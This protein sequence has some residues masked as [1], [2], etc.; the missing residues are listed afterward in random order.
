MPGNDPEPKK[1]AEEIAAEAMAARVAD[2][3]GLVAWMRANGVR[4][5]ADAEIELELEPNYRPAPLRMIRETREDRFKR[6]DAEAEAKADNALTDEQKK[7]KEHDRYW[8]RIT[9]SSGAPIP[10]F[11][12]EAPVKS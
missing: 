12:G 3:E 1:T 2:M 11:R 9:R 4:K 5:F 8:K 6:E 10:P 7:R